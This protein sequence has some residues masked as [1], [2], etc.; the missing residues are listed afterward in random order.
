MS[1]RRCRRERRRRR[2]ST[3]RGCAAV[4]ARDTGTLTQVGYLARRSITRTVRQP[5]MIVPSLVFPLF[6]L[7]VNS[8]GLEAATLAPGLSRP[9][10][11]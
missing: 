4:G 3:T 7:A 11:T 2:R 1:W 10:P 5:I 6:L 8:S 9:T